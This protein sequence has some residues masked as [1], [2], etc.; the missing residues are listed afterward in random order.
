MDSQSP[1]ISSFIIRFVLNEAQEGVENS[2]PHPYRG[3]IRHIQSEEELN[4]HLWEEA[5]EFIRRY[6]PLETE[7]GQDGA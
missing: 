4:F 5:V 6:V 7:S 2:A 3:S 1:L